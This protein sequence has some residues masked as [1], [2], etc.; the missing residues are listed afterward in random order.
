MFI[1]RNCEPL[2]MQMNRACKYQRAPLQ[3]TVFPPIAPSS[4]CQS[5]LFSASTQGFC[6][7]G[8]CAFT[9]RGVKSYSSD[10]TGS[11]K[12][13]KSRLRIGQLQRGSDVCCWPACLLPE[14]PRSRSRTAVC[15]EAVG[16]RAPQWRGGEGHVHFPRSSPALRD[17]GVCDSSPTE[18]RWEELIGREAGMFALVCCQRPSTAFV[19][20]LYLC[21]R[22]TIT[23][24]PALFLCPKRSQFQ[25]TSPAFGLLGKTRL[26][27]AFPGS[28]FPFLMWIRGKSVAGKA[29]HIQSVGFGAAPVG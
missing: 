11:I 4:C 9:W 16:S 27:I 19:A 25:F 1:K 2:K 5:P 8:F 13:E 20:Y 18:S 23:P 21:S 29:V 10:E 6:L 15:Q 3:Y 24:R 28:A 12:C 7:L 26:R 22:R 17:R 14:P